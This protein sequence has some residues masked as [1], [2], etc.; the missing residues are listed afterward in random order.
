MSE[1]C[2]WYQFK[3][4]YQ[5]ITNIVQ[6]GNGDLVADSHK[7]LNRRRNHFC[8]L[9]TVQRINDVRQTEIDAEES[10]V[11]EQSVFEVEMAIE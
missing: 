11:P 6:D 1:I 10:L 8:H 7:M 3:E 2:T 9:L 4:N 5:P